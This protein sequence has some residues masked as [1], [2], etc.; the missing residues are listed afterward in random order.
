MNPLLLDGSW[1]E[2]DRCFEVLDPDD[3]SVVAHVA[4]AD[5]TDA[6]R[7]VDAAAAAMCNPLPAHRRRAILSEVAC[8]LEAEEEESAQLIA[9]EGI[10]TIREARVEASRAS[11]TIRLCAEEVAQPS[12]E[13]LA[14]ESTAAG[15]RRFG[16]CVRQP[17]GV[18]V[19]I[20][21]FN[22]PLN[23][24][25]HK[26]GP[27]FAA[28][29]AIIVKPDSKTPVSALRL[30]RLFTD[31]GI[32]PGWLQV[33]PGAG[34]ELGPPMLAHDDVAMVSLTGGVDAGQAIA[35]GAGLKKVGMELGANNAAIVAADA[36][37]EVAV[38]KLGSG[39]FWAAGQNC[40]HVQRIYVE[41]RIL[42]HVVG[43]LADYAAS[44]TTGRK[45][46][47]ATD[48]G[49]LIDQVAQNRVADMV[50]EAVGSGA[51]VVAGGAVTERGF[52]PTILT[53][54]DPRCR[55]I[56]EEIYGPVTTV[57]PF[58]TLDEAI[59]RANDTPYGLAGAVFTSRIDT[60]FEVASRLDVGGVMINE[61]TDYRD[62]GMP[63]GGGGHSGIGREGVRAAVEELSEPKTIVF[64]GVTPIGAG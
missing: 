16:L 62:D 43:G 38:A 2:R 35:A 49:P 21:P 63:F 55:V 18:V 52:E 22:D 51:T 5:A 54:V 1:E 47:E 56:R 27:A 4:Q 41:E 61:S 42:D 53:G 25:A 31:A 14:L 37:L 30:A 19:G 15:E 10:K 32:P 8:R 3:D 64:T 26:V 57:S 28:G 60:A 6:V 46:D 40:L 13:T 12:G 59:A 33:L 17:M 20:T 58:R 29:N 50:A 36:D 9:R 24:V 44:V 23:L 11:N 45:L 7:A 48:M 39:M 34:P